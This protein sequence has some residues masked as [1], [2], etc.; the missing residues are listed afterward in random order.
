M[1]GVN[2][3]LAG[4]SYGVLIGSGL[5]A[6][7]AS[8]S[9]GLLRK[10]VVPVV[11]DTNVHAAWGGVL[12]E[13]FAKAG[14]EARFLIHDPG[15]SAKS[16]AGLSR[17]VEWLLELGVERG[18]N[19]VALGGGVI[20]D[21]TGF[22]AAILKRGCGFIQ[23]PTTLLAQV[24]SSVGG[25]TAI[26]VAAG[27][28]LV[29]AFHQPSLVLADLATLGTLPD[30][31]MRCGY[32]EIIKYGI[33]GDAAF[34]DW[35]EANGSAMIAR[36]ADALEYAVTTSVRAKVRIVAEDE[37]ET[38]GARALLNLG[39][40]FGHALEAETDYSEKLLHGEAVALGMVL[41]ARY[42]ARRGL[43][44]LDD[45]ARITAAIDAVGLPSEIAA[46][47][48]DCDG[49][50]LAAHM[51]HDKKMDAGTLPFILLRGIGDAFLDREV[52]MADIAAFLTE[53]LQAH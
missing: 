38:S 20:G 53:Q 22:A 10:P 11:T 52:D 2:V 24:D 8:L 6:D 14:H 36:E 33:L 30:R 43:V 31:E 15:E 3:D 26:N 1:A 19:I 5:L 12:A 42:S 29:G 51:L 39:H 16:W 49:Q 28:N 7:A 9:G 48:L 41:A 44:S 40:T 45:A 50:T 4:R 27:K 18:D 17:T 46:L 35:C 32:A 25:K 47:G 37:R 13:S 23:I 34:F 21:L